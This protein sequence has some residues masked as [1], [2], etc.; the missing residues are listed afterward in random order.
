[1]SHAGGQGSAVAQQGS[2]IAGPPSCASTCA[3]P[4]RSSGTITQQQQGASR[5]LP[6]PS[7]A[8][9]ET[10]TCGQRLHEQVG[11]GLWGQHLPP[12]QLRLPPLQAQPGHLV[13]QERVAHR[14]LRARVVG[15]G[16]GELARGV[17]LGSLCAP[18]CPRLQPK[19]AVIVA[20]CYAAAP[21][22]RPPACG[23]TA[24]GGRDRAAAA[25][26]AAAP[27][28]ATPCSVPATA[29]LAPLRRTAL[30]RPGPAG[31][32]RNASLCG[33]LLAFMERSWAV[34]QGFMPVPGLCQS[35]RSCA[36][37]LLALLHLL[38]LLPFRRRAYTAEQL[39]TKLRLRCSSR[40]AAF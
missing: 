39:D 3:L 11:H 18:G 23:H 35:T 8:Q 37:L 15:V 34:R 40:A 20:L 13:L 4:G 9:Q 12:R 19:R 25:P 16:D 6:C 10:P 5:R 36:H 38:P 27:L 32:C 29:W 1:M 17:Q 26:P 30:R 33:S 31:G 2:S 14:R 7:P 21:P 24:P 22:S 28:A